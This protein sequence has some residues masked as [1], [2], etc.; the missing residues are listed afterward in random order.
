MKG[1]TAMNP[2]T[3]ALRRR[4]APLLVALTALLCM[5]LALITVPASAGT[6]ATKSPAPVVE[7]SGPQ[8]LTAFQLHFHNYY[9]GPVSI[10]LMYR[11]Y[12][13]T[14]DEYSGWATRG[15]WN[16]AADEDKYVLNT[17]NRYV[18][19]Y[20]YSWD[21]QVKW[22]GTAQ[23]I[24]VDPDKAFRSCRDIGTSGWDYVGLRQ[25]DMGSTFTVYTVNLRGPATS[26]P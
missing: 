19:Y 13:G 24:Y 17:K 2:H 25:I 22:E 9:G 21:G 4:R 14:C 16:V 6:V 15:W 23:H 1:R 11:D 8:A 3:T 18:Y 20:A 12:T 26:A 5:A 10:A 7:Q